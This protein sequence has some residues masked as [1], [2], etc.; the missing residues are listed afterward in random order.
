MDSV[1]WSYWEFVVLKSLGKT[2]GSDAFS[3]HRFGPLVK[4]LVYVRYLDGKEEDYGPKDLYAAVMSWVR[5]TDLN[6]GVDMLTTVF[7]EV[8]YKLLTAYREGKIY[9]LG[10]D[11]GYR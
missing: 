5:A 8:A 11:G 10:Y 4:Y 3:Y 6:M 9:C 7:N 2:V 1:G